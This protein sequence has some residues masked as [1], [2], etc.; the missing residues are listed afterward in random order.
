MGKNLAVKNL[1]GQ[2]AKL[3]LDTVEQKTA[4]KVQLPEVVLDQAVSPQENL[5]PAEQNAA[6]DPLQ[7]RMA[8]E[9]HGKVGA[10]AHLTSFQ[11]AINISHVENP[12]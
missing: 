1:V 5:A 10:R 4:A 11:H 8:R 6:A 7:N 9:K 3:N 12:G 2:K